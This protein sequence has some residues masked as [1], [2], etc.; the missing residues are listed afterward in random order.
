MGTKTTSGTLFQPELVT[1]MFDKVKG[2][3]TL[4]KLS[5]ATQQAPFV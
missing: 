2:H 1:Q 4:A 3:S 5:G